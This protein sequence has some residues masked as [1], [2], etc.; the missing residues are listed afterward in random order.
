MMDPSLPPLPLTAA[1]LQL[2]QYETVSSSLASMGRIV[3]TVIR[4]VAFQLTRQFGT[5]EWFKQQSP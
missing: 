3:C 1:L 4:C 2:K 5:Q